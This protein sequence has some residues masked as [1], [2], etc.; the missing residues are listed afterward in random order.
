MVRSTGHRRVLLIRAAGF[1]GAQIARQ[2]V[3]A[4]VP[5]DEVRKSNVQGTAGGLVRGWAK[6][7]LA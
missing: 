1:L 3:C 7:I 6:A 5:L 4:N 2:Q